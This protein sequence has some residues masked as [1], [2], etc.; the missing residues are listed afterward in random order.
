MLIGLAG[1]AQVGKDEVANVLVDQGFTR[2][3][4][5]D[6]LKELATA[7]H[8]WS[9]SKDELGR[10]HLQ[11]LGNK[12]RDIL[13]DEIWINAALSD[14]GHLDNVVVSDVRYINE[15]HAIHK[16][17]GLV[18]R[19]NRPGVG[20]VNGH[21][22]EALPEHSSL[23]DGYMHNDGTLD[24]LRRKVLKWVDQQRI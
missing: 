10:L 3:A 14:I 2:R 13:G 4:F 22:S 5:A 11:Y 8:Y 19:I 18:L 23:Y 21:V 16:A 17:G 6:K 12:V 15:V 1:Y 7:L 20:P 9:G 24:E